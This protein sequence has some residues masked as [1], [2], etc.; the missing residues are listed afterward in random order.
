M[1]QP[2]W[3]MI[4]SYFID[5]PIETV[6]SEINEEMH[7]HLSRGRYQLCTENAIYSF[8]DLYDNYTK[9]FRQL[10]LDR[11]PSQEILILGF[12]LGSIPLI[13]EKVFDRRYQ[14]TGIEKDETVIHLANKYTLPEIKSS[15]EMIC[16]DA[17]SFVR[18]T[19]RQY[20]MICMDVYLDDQVP[21]QFENI[22]FLYQL[23][24][25]LHPKGVLLFNKLYRQEADKIQT[26]SFFEL[27]FQHVFSEAT[28]LD[29]DGNWMLLNNGSL[30]KD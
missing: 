1:K 28:Y 17:A 23:Q 15:I 14:F 16:T 26:Q 12:G 5:F 30:L 21:E 27:T 4:A 9:S 10:D 3:K 24:E 13:L 2:I 18:Q 19:T 20:A 8:G 22:Q 11:L 25:I 6:Y 7:I 29:V